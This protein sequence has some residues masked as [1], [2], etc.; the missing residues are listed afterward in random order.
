ATVNARGVKAI[1]FD[2]VELS[3][4]DRGIGIDCGS[5]P[6]RLHHVV[7][8][9]GDGDPPSAILCSA[10]NVSCVRPIEVAV[11]DADEPRETGGHDVLASSSPADAPN[12][13]A[14]R[15]VVDG[16]SFHRQVSYRPG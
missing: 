9:L 8:E 6:D 15:R 11:V 4:A 16:V 12:A 14:G 2:P 13:I 10:V 1:R 3:S 7:L 5:R